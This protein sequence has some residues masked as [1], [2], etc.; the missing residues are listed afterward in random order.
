MKTRK[1]KTL[2]QIYI[3]WLDLLWGIIIHNRDKETCQ[4]C[5]RSYG[6]IDAHHIHGRGLFVRWDTRNGILL[7]YRCHQHRIH[8]DHEGLRKVCVKKIGQRVYDQLYFLSHKP[9]GNV[10]FEHEEKLLLDEM[11][12]L[13]IT[14]PS[15]PKRLTEQLK[16]PLKSKKKL[17]KK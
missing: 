6:K 1:I 13:H 2:R 5:E 17:G 16:L 12:D 15:K 7:C 4:W 10:D 14:P 3:K 11:K 8:T 9:C